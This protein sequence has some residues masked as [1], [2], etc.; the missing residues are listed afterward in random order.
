M[1]GCHVRSLYIIVT[2]ILGRGKV[3]VCVFMLS[4]VRF[5]ECNH[6]PTCQQKRL[7]HSYYIYDIFMHCFKSTQP[8]RSCECCWVDLLCVGTKKTSHRRKP[9]VPCLMSAL[10][11]AHHQPWD[12]PAGAETWVSMYTHSEPVNVQT[13]NP[14]R[15]RPCKINFPPIR[16]RSQ[17]IV[18][19]LCFPFPF[20][21]WMVLRSRHL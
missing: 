2:H 20:L 19:L 15:L 3:G 13:K 7:I 12:S 18:F 11:T 6:T 16:Y 8:H 1:R 21:N 10:H 17:W 9:G 4:C 14:M 5:F